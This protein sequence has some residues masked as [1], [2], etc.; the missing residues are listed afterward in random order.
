MSGTVV[1]DIAVAGGDGSGYQVPDLFSTGRDASDVHSAI[2]PSYMAVF[3][4][5][6]TSDSANQAT[7]AQW[8]VFGPAPSNR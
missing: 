1:P 4:L 5:P 3:L 8:P 7:E 2:E 6:P